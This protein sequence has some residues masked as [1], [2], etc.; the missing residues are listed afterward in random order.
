VQ[1]RFITGFG[2][3]HSSTN[4]TGDISGVPYDRDSSGF[5]WQYLLGIDVPISDRWALFTQYRYRVLPEL[6]YVSNFNDF[7]FT[8]DDKPSAHSVSFGARVS[9]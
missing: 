9:F 6:T 7:R 5:A 4:M 2:I 8:T 1:Q 3:G